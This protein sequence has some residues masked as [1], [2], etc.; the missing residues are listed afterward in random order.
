[1]NAYQKFRFYQNAPKS[2]FLF[3]RKSSTEHAHS[4]V[5]ITTVVH[6]YVI[7]LHICVDFIDNPQEHEFIDSFLMSALVGDI[8][9][10]VSVTKNNLG[11][12]PCHGVAFEHSRVAYTSSLSARSHRLV[13]DKEVVLFLLFQLPC[14]MKPCQTVPYNY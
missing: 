11:L 3:S 7:A 4:F 1:M 10:V 13:C 6:E 5:V 2:E 8:G 9:H 12:L 14:I